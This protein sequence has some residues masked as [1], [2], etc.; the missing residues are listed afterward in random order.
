MTA[1]VNRRAE[2]LSLLWDDA[3]T[4]NMHI[5]LTWQDGDGVDQQA[6]VHAHDKIVSAAMPS[7][8]VSALYNIVLIPF[9]GA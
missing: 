8:Q 5:T 4:A 1:C 6:V 2:L 3:P 9:S 7:I